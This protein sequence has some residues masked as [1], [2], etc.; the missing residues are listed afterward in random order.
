MAVD[1]LRKQPQSASIGPDQTV[2][3][4]RRLAAVLGAV[5]ADGV[6]E[7]LLH[8]SS[9]SLS[10]QANP[11]QLKA[12]RAA[13]PDACFHLYLLSFKDRPPRSSEASAVSGASLAS[14]DVGSVTK[15]H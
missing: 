13:G 6:L 4:M 3:V 8:Q 15:R 12:R 2:I 10:S 9:P 5:D 1:L 11:R 14:L 7:V